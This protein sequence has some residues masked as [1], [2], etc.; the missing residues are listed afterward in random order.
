MQKKIPQLWMD[1]L[2]SR[3]LPA[4]LSLYAPS[5]VLIPTFGAR[6]LRGRAELATYFKEFVGS[7]PNLCGSIDSIIKQRLPGA[8]TIWSGDYTFRWSGGVSK[9][10]YTFV[11]SDF[12][13]VTHHSSARP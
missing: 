2:C 8:V 11:H 6:V 7:R 4:V 9:A 13:I 10:R 1:R 5:A 3:S 12:G